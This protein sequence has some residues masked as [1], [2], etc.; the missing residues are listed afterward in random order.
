MSTEFI[1][2]GEEKGKRERGKAYYFR[3][4]IWEI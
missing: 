4:P 2:F 3:C 1:S